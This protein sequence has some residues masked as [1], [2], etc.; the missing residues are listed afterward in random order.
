MKME[1]NMNTE[2][3]ILQEKIQDESS[4]NVK[5]ENNVSEKHIDSSSE[6]LSLE[7][8]LA[9][10]KDKFL[11]LYA[12]FDNYKKRSNKEK[13]NLIKYGNSEI[14]SILIPVIDDFERA[15]KNIQKHNENN[16]F[17]GVQLIQN[18]FLNIL[19]EK[20]LKKMDTKIG[21]DFNLDS[22]EAISQIPAPKEELKNKVLDIIETGY[23]LHDKV[24]R[25]A[26]VVV[27]T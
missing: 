26:K 4:N 20:G 9:Q 25:F 22:H 12:D 6:R 3:N 13:F 14:L 15:I 17:S 19:K 24:I 16:I 11:R 5:I 21:D 7:D 10:E 8:Q 23:M 27:G 1:N 2:D 18:K